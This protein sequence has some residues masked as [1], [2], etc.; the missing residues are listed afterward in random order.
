M[1]HSAFPQ[2]EKRREE[3]VEEE[4]KVRILFKVHVYSQSSCLTFYLEIKR[5]TRQCSWRNW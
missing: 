3:S 2:E 1:E 5:K 4:V